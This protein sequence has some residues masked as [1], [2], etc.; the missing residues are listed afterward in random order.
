MVQMVANSET[1]P[2]AVAAEIAERHAAAV[3]FPSMLLAEDAPVGRIAQRMADGRFDKA[4]LIS[5]IERFAGMKA[6]IPERPGK[7]LFVVPQHG[8]WAAELTLPDQVFRTAGYEADYV[9]P[10]GQRPFVFGVSIDTTFR[11]QAWNAAQVSAGEAALGARYNDRTTPEG[12]RLNQP[13][14]LDDWL[15]PTPRPA[16]RRAIAGALP[17]QAVRGAARG[18]LNTPPWSSSAV[19]EPTWTW[20]ATPRSVP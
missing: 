2:E 12:Q 6:D 19:P 3:E 9:T 10:R 5:E 18:E 15:P 11:D 7:V 13:R 20:A 1:T 16:T 8:Y 14:N 4:L 17:Q